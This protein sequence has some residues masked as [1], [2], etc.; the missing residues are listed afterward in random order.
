MYESRCG[1]CC[2][3]CEGKADV[4]CRGCLNMEKPF[5]GGECAVKTC[6][7]SRGLNH[8]GECGEFPCETLSSM[9]AEEGYDPQPKIRRCRAWALEK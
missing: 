4:G 9:G 2:E 8:C 5:W 1:I 3:S 7:E 6:C